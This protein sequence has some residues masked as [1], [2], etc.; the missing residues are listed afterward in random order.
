MF[1]WKFFSV[2]IVLVYFLPISDYA[3]GRMLDKYEIGGTEILFWSQYILRFLSNQLWNVF[4]ICRYNATPLKLS[5]YQLPRAKI[6]TNYK[7]QMNQ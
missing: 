5:M 2:D 3:Y 4:E 7:F 6:N 1:R